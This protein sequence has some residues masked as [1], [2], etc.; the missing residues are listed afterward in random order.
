M[1]AILE[2]LRQFFDELRPWVL[3]SPWES[4]V[5]VRFGSRTKVC[6]PGVHFKI[7]VFDEFHSF[8]VVPRV[9]S[10]HHQSLV[11][12]DGHNFAVSGALGYYVADAEK[13]LV[14]V[15][16]FENSIC[17][18]AMGLIADYITNH[19]GVDC[20]HDRV[21]E[22]VSNSLSEAVESWGIDLTHVYLVDFADVKTFRLLQDSQ[23]K[24][25]TITIG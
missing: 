22:A 10:L 5:R 7:P 13:A 3:V 21:Q 16:D 18:L 4:S 9:V 17:N 14:E 12:A 11:T 23:T 8:N 15:D 20:T 19:N 24:Q 25:P 2:F 1:Q 6:K